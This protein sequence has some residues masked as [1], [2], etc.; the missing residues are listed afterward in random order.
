M[1]KTQHTS[2]YVDLLPCITEF[3]PFYLNNHFNPSKEVLLLRGFYGKRDRVQTTGHARL[4]WDRNTPW[5]KELYK[6]VMQKFYPGKKHKLLTTDDDGDDDGGD[7]VAAT[8]N[9]VSHTMTT[10][11]RG[12]A[13]DALPTTTEPQKR[14]RSVYAA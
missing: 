3:A 10:R 4:T 14:T 13:A 12:R 5:D 9:E 8:H 6:K 2:L 1:V 11:R 7:D